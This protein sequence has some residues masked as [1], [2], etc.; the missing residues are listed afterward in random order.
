VTEHHHTASYVASVREVR[1]LGA[2]V[3]LIRAAV[4][5]VPPGQGELNPAVNAIQS[6]VLSESG[7][8]LLIALLQNT[9]AA[10]HQNPAAA[11]ALT[12]ELTDVLRAGQV[13]Q[14]V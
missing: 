4:G 7:G 8:A 13:V 12:S 3:I 9:P 2:G 11:E 10:F 1:Q 5:M 6:A 14:A